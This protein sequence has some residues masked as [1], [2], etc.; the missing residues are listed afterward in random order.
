MSDD[1]RPARLV[2]PGRILK[3]ELDAR[4]W[5]QRDL[6]AILG[7]PEQAI[8]EIINGSKQITPETSVELSQA[9]GTSPEFWHNLEAEY[10]LELALR[11]TQDD[12][13]ARRSQLYAELPLRE[14]ASRGWLTLRKS[15]DE[16]EA[17]VANCLGV[18]V[19]P[20][21]PR[22]AAHWRGSTSRAPL[23]Y[24]LL[25]WLRRAEMLARG[26]TA[27][28]PWRGDHLEPL[29]RELS[30]HMG[31]V[32]GV[33]QVPSTLARWGVRL[34]FLRHLT[35]TYL[36]GAAFW[37]EE[38]PVVA[39]TLR[40]DR[41]DSFWFTLM[42]ELAHL[43]EGRSEAY[44]DELEGG[45]TDGTAEPSPAD[46]HEK[47]ANRLASRWLLAPEAFSDFVARTGPHFS[48]ASIEAFAV[49]QGRHPGIVLGRLQREGL[50]PYRT[51]R[52][53][54]VKVSPVLTADI[55]Y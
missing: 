55:K 51:L 45:D 14:M 32:E 44:L 4:G 41:I 40:Y 36:D 7:R 39:L 3:Q 10:R 25:A 47:A 20:E 23:T 16:L 1:L 53:L 49:S 19:L 28:G 11:Q 18:P 8:S 27:V 52:G 33:A 15:A 17:E 37:L 12:A 2:P 46:P 6:A 9:F 30:G 13:I 29:V 54:L 50:V 42:H 31:L 5:T 35:K 48:R 24:A 22:L 26:Q 38:G 21:P 34:V 43:A